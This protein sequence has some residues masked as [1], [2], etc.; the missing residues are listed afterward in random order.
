MS[1]LIHTART[2]AIAGLL[3]LSC[4]GL[5][6]PAHAL[7]ATG[8]FEMEFV[9]DTRI[10]GASG[11]YLSLCHLITQNGAWGLPLM[12]VSKDYVLA[13]NGCMARSYYQMSTSDLVQAQRA[14]AIS[15]DIALDPSLGL[16][17]NLR[18]FLFL[19]CLGL[20]STHGILSVLRRRHLKRP[21]KGSQR[22]D[23]PAFDAS[24]EA[25]CLLARADGQIDENK[26]PVISFACSNLLGKIVGDKKIN[27]MLN[28]T[29]PELSESDFA[30]F[31]QGLS[32]EERRVMM[33][34][35]LTVAVSDGKIAGAQQTFIGRLARATKIS[36]EEVGQILSEIVVERRPA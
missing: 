4:L 11:R 1:H 22:I 29:M 3:S 24:F 31:S 5:S 10:A 20:L 35:V 34:A 32:P 9:T 21:A 30:K 25:M 12:S 23:G 2:V 33:R 14:G 16:F 7:S 8:H 28:E 26:V 13:E 17:R 19:T 27:K 6:H 36:L 18:N 15:A